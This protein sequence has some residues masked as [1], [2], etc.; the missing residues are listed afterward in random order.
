MADPST[1]QSVAISAEDLLA[2]LEAT[3]R[4][5]RR[6]VLRATPP[7]SGRMR[8]RLH[9]V[10]GETDDGTL[11]FPPGDLVDGDAPSFPT[12]DETADELRERDDEPYSVDRHREYHARRVD[13]W[14]DAVPDH[15]V[16][17]VSH[18]AVGHEV[19]VSL[20]GP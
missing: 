12:P 17:A 13:E 9:V 10:Q 11:H 8:A 2:A 7:Y 1:V 4:D 20:L 3:A 16:D 15:V 14:R 5:E 18:P 19:A 6:T